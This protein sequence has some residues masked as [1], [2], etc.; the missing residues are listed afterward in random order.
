MK[1]SLERLL[2]GALSDTTSCAGGGEWKSLE[3]AKGDLIPRSQ[4]VRAL[5]SCP[6]ALGV[7]CFITTMHC[8]SST[9]P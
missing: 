3:I 5:E 9:E 2:D 7:Y 1:Q 8:G 6:H 4:I